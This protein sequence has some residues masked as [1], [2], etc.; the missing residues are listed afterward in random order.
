MYSSI[1][2]IIKINKI[3]FEAKTQF[4]KTYVDPINS[5]F[6]YFRKY[7]ELPWIEQSNLQN[8]KHVLYLK[9]FYGNLQHFK[10]TLMDNKIL[11]FLETI[12]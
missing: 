10:H 5:T 11:V 12:L 9:H 4:T 1:I 2:I 6:I 8:F 7:K 3:F